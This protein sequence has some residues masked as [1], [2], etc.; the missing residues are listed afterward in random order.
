MVGLAAAVLP[1]FAQAQNH[2]DDSSKTTSQHPSQ[3]HTNNTT[4]TSQHTNI[5]HN[6]NPNNTTGL[7]QQTIESINMLKMRKTPFIVALNKIDR[8]YGWQSEPDAPVRDAFKRQPPHVER[9]F[10]DRSA[11]V[12]LQLNEQGLN[13]ALYWKNPDPRKCVCQVL[14]C[15]FFVCV[16]WG[17]W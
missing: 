5:T 14:W 17:G 11:Q 2:T 10:E 13:V 12:F 6:T 1:C 3:Q 4:H 15:L 9:E 7:E 8:L 16:F